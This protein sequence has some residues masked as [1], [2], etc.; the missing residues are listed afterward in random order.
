MQVSEPVRLLVVD[1]DP[2]VLSSFRRLAHGLQLQMRFAE[3]AEDA[4]RQLDAETP[5]IIICDYR[6]PGLDGLSFLERVHDR[7]PDVKRILHTG[8]AIQR[9]SFG[10]DVPVLAKPCSPESLRELLESF[11]ARQI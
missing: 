9:T 7:H 2:R 5:D 1:D 6:L 10:V 11:A 3:D 4:Q 8:E